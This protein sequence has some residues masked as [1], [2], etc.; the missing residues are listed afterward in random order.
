MTT[1]LDKVDLRDIDELPCTVP[2]IEDD[3]HMNL[4][5]SNISIYRNTDVH[6]IPP[7]KEFFFTFHTTLDLVSLYNII[8]RLQIIIVTL[9]ALLFLY[10]IISV[11]NLLRT[12]YQPQ[13]I[14]SGT[15]N[16]SLMYLRLTCCIP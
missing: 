4:K 8:R 7:K 12:K 2:S 14:I 10:R 11:F 16:M 13:T 5:Y 3:L 1:L 9:D 6:L 15:I